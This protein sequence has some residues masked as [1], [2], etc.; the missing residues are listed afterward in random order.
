MLEVAILKGIGFSAVAV[1]VVAWLAVSFQSPGRGQTLAAR[2]AAA[3]MYVA[4]ICLFIHLTQDNWEKERTALVVPFGF[5]LAVFVCGLAIT[6]VKGFGELA[7]RASS[8]GSA[9]H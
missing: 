3:A 1:L 9:T 6:L 5:L 8:S 2:A 7:G 4:L